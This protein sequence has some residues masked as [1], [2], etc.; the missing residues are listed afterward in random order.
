MSGDSEILDQGCSK[1][2]LV[3]HVIGYRW[4]T[5]GHMIVWGN[6]STQR[7]VCFIPTL[8]ITYLTRKMLWFL[9][10]ILGHIT[11]QLWHNHHMLHNRNLIFV[12]MKMQFELGC[13][14]D[15]ICHSPYSNEDILGV[16]WEWTCKISTDKFL[17]PYQY[18]CR[19]MSIFKPCM[20]YIFVNMAYIA[21]KNIYLFK[22]AMHSG[23]H[24]V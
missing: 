21:G 23:T 17:F 9:T 11:W 13:L 5:S 24:S 16:S 8:F 1:G 4:S 12:T 7:K 15:D 10:L 2:Q 20:F 22:S 6:W 19:E 3:L 14:N 18:H